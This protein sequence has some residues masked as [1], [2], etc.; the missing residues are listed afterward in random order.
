[1]SSGAK[2]LLDVTVASVA[3]VI[4]APLLAVFAGLIFFS[5][6]G[7]P[8]YRGTRVGRDRRAFTLYKFRTMRLQRDG[9]VWSDTTALDDDRVLPAGRVLRRHKL[10]ELPQLLNVL[11]GDM[12]L[13]GPRPE[14]YA[15]VALYSETDSIV[16]AARPGI[17]DEAS[18]RFRHLDEVVGTGS[19]AHD[20]YL[21]SVF[22]EKNRLRREYVEQASFALDI[23][24]LART[25]ATLWG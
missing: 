7:N 24:I 9:E 20:R 22:P 17:T 1:M 16:F 14:T 4:V 10:D 19:D 18:L 15:N 6:R 12:S 25:V 5:D 11:R 2:R 13:V 8:L 23:S 21:V 3:L